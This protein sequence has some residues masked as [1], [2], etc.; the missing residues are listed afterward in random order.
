M[1]KLSE[2]KN[3]L[4]YILLLFIFIH[5]LSPCASQELRKN[6]N[7]TILKQWTDRNGLPHRSIFTIIQ[8]QDGYLWLGTQ[9]GLVRFD[10]VYMTVFDRWNTPVLKNDCILSLH[11]DRTGVIWIGTNGG[12]LCKWK[13][14]Q[15]Y[16]DS[17]NTYFHDH[18]IRALTSDLYNR[19]WIGTEYGLYRFENQGIEIF[20]EKQ[21][22]LDN[23]I[24]SLAADS[25]GGVWVASLQGGLAYFE[26]DLIRVFDE[27]D[28]L[29]NSSVLSVLV[30]KDNRIYTGTLKGAYRLSPVKS[31]FEPVFG[32]TYTPI[33][34]LA[35]SGEQTLWM[36][37]INDGLLCQ[38]YNRPIK[39]NQDLLFSANIQTLFVDHSGQ[40]WM[41][42]KNSG[43]LRYYPSIIS[44]L[45][46]RGLPDETVNCLL[47]TPDIRVWFGTDNG[48]YYTKKPGNFVV[49]TVPTKIKETVRTLHT[50]SKR[51]L[52][53]GTDQTLY[54]LSFLKGDYHILN[55]IPSLTTIS[56]I[57][58]DSS[59]NIWVGT[60]KG[61]YQ[62]TNLQ[63]VTLQAVSS[64]ADFAIRDMI[65][66][67]NG[68]LFV[69]TRERVW[70]HSNKG[71]IPLNQIS[72]PTDMNV[73]CLYQDKT[74]ILWAGTKGGGL[75]AYYEKKWITLS[76]QN[77]LPD[78]FIYTITPDRQGELWMS[79]NKGIFHVPEDSLRSFLQKKTAWLPI[80]LYDENQGMTDQRCTTTGYPA[81]LTNESGDRWYSTSGGI[82]VFPNSL[83]PLVPVHP[84]VIIENIIVDADTLLPEESITLPTP[85]RRLLINFTGFDFQSPEKLR[86]RYR[87]TGIDSMHR[88]VFPGESRQA[89]YLKPK[90]GNH[91]FSI[92]AIS[93]QRIKSQ[94]KAVLHITILPPLYRRPL[95]IGLAGFILLLTAA[96]T[97]LWRHLKIKRKKQNKYK[98]THVD[99]KRAAKVMLG[100]REAMQKEH[101]YLNP[102]LTLTE[103]SKKL[104]IHSNYLSRLI[105]EKFGMS[106]SDYVNRYRIQ[107]AKKLLSDPSRKNQTVL[108]ILYE[109]GF[110]SKSVFNTAFKKFTGETPSG[111]RKKH[112]S[113]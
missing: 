61:L 48:L 69:A 110:Y 108:E 79:T 111:F 102:N 96:G 82:T 78:N 20:T 29:Q 41:G 23:I 55:T 101:M 1:N 53:V 34:A 56:I 58:S 46:V 86:F 60:E 25:L 106:Y 74:G 64:L 28:G 83:S 17:R 98:T 93:N 71:Y 33:T 94:K 2:L 97:F 81:L 67:G 66:S 76:T 99:S 3:S 12:G 52:W 68:P 32:T 39:V 9:A 15:F 14:G 10:G 105:N 27:D 72:P 24:T 65:M 87:M 26:D 90:P 100:L 91:C 63:P 18:H 11:Q 5:D 88:S 54:R 51:N 44:V 92:Q 103:L 35:I 8:D 47:Q 113:S 16:R 62:I 38:K 50:D 22:L 75:K 77:G 6:V 36:G 19:L 95:F 70:K 7:N 109:V 30:R 104:K 45:E 31:L 40:I 80:T 89:V 43:L 13:N 85:P 107:E 49:H 21:G 84:D 57:K 73:I 112:L 37:T 4:L 59:G 42:T